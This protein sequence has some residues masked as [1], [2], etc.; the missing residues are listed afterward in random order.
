MHNRSRTIVSNQ[1][2][3]H[4]NLA[5]TVARHLGQRFLAPIS[6]RSR[7][8]FAELSDWRQANPKPLVLDSCCGVGE[9]TANLAKR[10]PEAIVLGIDKSALRID[11]H[12]HYHNGVDNY[13]V[14]RGDL[15]DLWRLM[16]DANWRL[17]HHYLL[18][19]NPWPKAAH[20]QRRWHGGPLFPS[21]L[22]LGGQLQLR[23]N[24]L[25]YLQEFQQ[26]LAVAGHQGQLAAL[27]VVE[28][29]TP[30]ER[31]YRDSGQSLYQLQ[32]NLS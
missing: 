25:I 26:A 14:V 17:S 13:R 12:S 9:S 11:K 21:L 5:T 18:Y 22:A 30:F 8:L 2:G 19:P 6:E 3:L 31:K 27:E 29:L 20:L 28:P 10:H 7:E 24:W 32:A 16:V 1:P 15:N 23:S 4:H